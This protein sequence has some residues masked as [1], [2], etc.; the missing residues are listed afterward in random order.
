M[1]DHDAAGSDEDALRSHSAD[2]AAVDPEHADR[3]NVD[4]DITN[5]TLAR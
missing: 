1:R 2:A 5:T 3:R 4:A